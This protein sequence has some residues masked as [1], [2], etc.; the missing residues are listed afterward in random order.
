[1]KV[2]TDQGGTNDKINLVVSNR[3]YFVYFVF[4][5]RLKRANEFD[6]GVMSTASVNAVR[7]SFM[8]LK[9]REESLNEREAQLSIEVDNERVNL[10]D[11][12]KR[13]DALEREIVTTSLGDDVKKSTKK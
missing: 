11:L 8:E 3:D 6:K 12:N 2:A 13:L 7:H 4:R 10:T 5:S 9:R 1:V